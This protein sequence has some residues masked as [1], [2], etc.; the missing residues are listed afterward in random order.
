MTTLALQKALAKLRPSVEAAQARRTALER[1]LADLTQELERLTT[2][3]VT[4]GPVPSLLDT[5]KDREGQREAL[6]RELSAW[7]HAGKQID[8]SKMERELQ[9]K[10][11]DWN[12]LLR[13]QVPQARQVLKKLLNGPIVFKP[14]RQQGERFYT[15]TAQISLGRLLS[16]TVGARWRPQRDSNPCFGLERATSW[17][18]GRWGRIETGRELPMI[19]R[20]AGVPAVVRRL[21]IP[22]CTWLRT[23]SPAVGERPRRTAYRYR[24]P[25]ET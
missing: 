16:G 15:F 2:A 23:A 8:W 3:I 22:W 7:E 4:T 10:L 9:A 6:T 5:V 14:F 21:N 18:S 11:A 1:R 17:A 19:P 25:R 20:T 24:A 12:G 13:R